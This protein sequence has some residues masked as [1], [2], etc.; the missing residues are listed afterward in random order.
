MSETTAGASESSPATRARAEHS[1]DETAPYRTWLAERIAAGGFSTEDALVAFLPLARDVAAQHALGG[2]APL[3]G[4][5]HIAVADGHLRLTP[6]RPAPLRSNPAAVEAADPPHRPAIEVSGEFHGIVLHEPEE[7][8]VAYGTVDPR[9]PP[10]VD[11]NAPLGDASATPAD[12]GYVTGYRVWEHLVG[13]H[14]PVTDVFSLGMI[15]AS[16]ACGLDLS[17]RESLER[18]VRHRRNLFELNPRLHPVVAKAIVRMTELSR[19]RRPQDVAGLIQSLE[20]Y[21]DQAIDLEFDLARVPGFRDSPPR[22]RRQRVLAVLQR[23]LFELS[24]RNRLLHF[25]NTSSTLNLTWASVP[26]SFAIEQIRPDELLTWND[27]FAKFITSGEPI[28]LGNHLRFEE[29]PYIPA[30][31]ERI[32]SEARRDQNEFGFHPLRLVLGFLRWTNLKESP[33]ERFDSPLVLLPV[34]LVKR[35]GVRD[36][37]QLEP[38][39]TEAEVNPVLRHYFKQLY[40]V[41]LP[42]AVDLE[43]TSLESLHDF[44]VKRIHASEPAVTIERIDRPRIALV[45]EKA[46]RWRERYERRSRKRDETSE[47]RPGANESDSATGDRVAQSE[48]TAESPD[49]NGPANR[50]FPSEGSS[51]AEAGDAALSPALETGS[52]NPPRTTYTFVDRDDAANPYQWE[53]DLCSVTLGNFRSRR[54]SLVR[55]YDELLNREHIH[56]GFDAVFSLAPRPPLEQP[57]LPALKD[58]Y[59]VVSCDPTQAAAIAYAASGQSYIIQGPPGTGK[60]QS[61]TNLIADFVSR[62]KRVL[63][64]CEKRA[65]ID[66]V[67]HRLKQRGLDSLCCLIHDSQS[68]KK[69][70]I[71]DLKATYEGH[72]AAAAEGTSDDAEADRT[73]LLKSLQSNLDAFAGFDRAMI[74]RCAAAGIPLR[75]LLLRTLELAE[76]APE[77]NADAQERIPLYRHWITGRDALA[78]LAER[79]ED[80]HGEGHNGILANHPLAE[81]KSS[82]ATADRPIEFVRQRCDK[83]I[84]QLERIRTTWNGL[85]TSDEVPGDWIGIRAAIVRAV[86]LKEWGQNHRTALLHADSPSARDFAE[87]LRQRESLVAAHGAAREAARAWRTVLTPQDSRTALELARAFD[88]KPFAVFRP[89]WWKLRGVLRRSYDFQASSIPRTWVQALGELEAVHETQAALDAFDVETR[90]RFRFEGDIPAFVRTLASLREAVGTEPPT[91][92]A[93]HRVL[94]DKPDPDAALL[95]MAGLESSVRELD[96]LLKALFEIPGRHD[97]NNLAATLAGIGEHLDDLPDFAPCLVELGRLPPELAEALRTEPLTLS[98]LEAASARRTLEAVCR[99]DRSLARFLKSRGKLVERIEADYQA[100]FDANAAVVRQQVRGR[101]LENVRISTS[102]TSGLTS[103]QREFRSQYAAGRKELEHEFGKTMRYKSIRELVGGASGLVVQDLKP[104]WLMSPLSVSDTL[105]L[106][107]MQVDV[108]LFDEASQITLEGAVPAAFRAPQMIVVGDEMQL[109]PTNFFGTRSNDESEELAGAEDGSEAEA[110]DG[111]EPAG[112]G[113]GYELDA[114][115]FLTHSSRHLPSAMLGWHYRSRSESLI[116]F[117][118]AAF[119]DGRLLTV[120]EEERI[121]SRREPIT[122]DARTLPALPADSASSDS[123][124]SSG[125][126]DA[127]LDRPLSFHFVAGAIYEERRNTAE[128]DH[129]AQLVRGLLARNEAAAGQGGDA[130]RL[131]LGIIA[132]SEAQ[133]GEIES[134]LDRLA[135]SDEAFRLRLEAEFERETDGQFSGLLVKNLE[136]I[137]GDE[138]DVVILSVCYGPDRAGKMRMGFGPINQSGGEKRLNVAFSRAK[139]H[140]ALVSSI[141][142]TQI[143]NDY[144]TGAATL[145]NYLRYAEASSEGDAETARRILAELAPAATASARHS[146]SDLVVEQLAAALV[147]RGHGVD[148]SVGQSHFRVDL[149]VF[150]DGDPRYRLGLLV[151]TDTHYRQR[152]LLEREVLRP[153]LLETFGWQVAHVL[154]LDWCL[155]R[156][157][158]LKRLEELMADA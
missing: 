1:L 128:A 108:V 11:G 132:F 96:E 146:S 41:A 90:R 141:R 59:P 39:G 156:A 145:K 47:S 123:S 58:R 24:R 18:F 136:N 55:D 117:S 36:A 54:T 28:T 6:H 106:D 72:L 92:A 33:P 82:I 10:I 67:Y 4:L 122:V 49:S 119:Y 34:T 23:R 150:K 131:S 126:V 53:F 22:D 113:R 110:A 88:G 152:D 121:A 75:E 124:P 142:S 38:H 3:D 30:A 112:N 48:G 86:Q 51:P 21:R 32:R 26:L 17:D 52:A 13:H 16:L 19:S 99:E 70:V 8:G 140:M 138:R 85:F 45:H 97:L 14:D 95:Q 76:T 137:Q 134:A 102:S 69:D 77:L 98:Q 35:K 81:L 62:G 103:E 63:F 144:N 31:L 143:T 151:D 89:R 87:A 105:P 107:R 43:E 44:L 91:S 129:I 46:Q 50:A 135:Q 20:N 71:H 40:D 125:A 133:Q 68:D 155:N 147:E 104:V 60:S 79:L 153:R 115:S 66:V 65:A 56:P 73:R 154:T 78:R 101:F 64:V 83:A 5:S 120:P 94:L 84:S 111:R 100:L 57:S 12:M 118:N 158:V 25:R 2:I 27:R 37:W 148:R 29:A 61:I 127:L 7:V 116:S 9:L 130:A 157:A 109:P 149:A 80:L 42:E 15:L 114:D 139:R 74:E 93:A